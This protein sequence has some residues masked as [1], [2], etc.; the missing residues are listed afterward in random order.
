M[1]SGFEYVCGELGSVT[2][3][4]AIPG[5]TV[6]GEHQITIGIGVVGLATDGWSSTIDS[7]SASLQITVI[8]TQSSASY[9][10]TC[11]A[12]GSCGIVVNMGTE[13]FNP[14]FQ[15]STTS[16]GSWLYLLG[17]WLYLLIVVFGFSVVIAII[18][19][20]GRMKKPKKTS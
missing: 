11:D 4:L 15:T 18:L 12:Q 20:S 2:F 6:V 1:E 3:S 14:S 8:Q 17:G 19:V 5:T 16:S 7:S 9:S 13:T 10:T